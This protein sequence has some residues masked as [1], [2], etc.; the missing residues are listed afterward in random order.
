MTFLERNPGN[1]LEKL[2]GKSLV[3]FQLISLEEL[4]GNLRENSEINLW[5]NSN[6]RRTSEKKNPWKNF[7]R[8]PKKNSKNSD[9]F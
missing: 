8:N 9:N 3:E 2:L 4:G 6:L 7:G 5:N 1:S